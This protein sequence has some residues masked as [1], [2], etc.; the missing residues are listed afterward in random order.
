MNEQVVAGWEGGLM[1]RCRFLVGVSSNNEQVGRLVGLLD[2]R[3]G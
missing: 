2:K 1:D 3:L